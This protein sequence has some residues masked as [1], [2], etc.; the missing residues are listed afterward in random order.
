MDSFGVELDHDLDRDQI[1]Q[2]VLHNCNDS[3]VGH[4]Y[5]FFTDDNP[6]LH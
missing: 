5:L 1:E 4:N 3:S 6:Y 2:A